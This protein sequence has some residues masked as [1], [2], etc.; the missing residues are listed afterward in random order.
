MPA[1]RNAV[2][3]RCVAVRR[4]DVCPSTHLA[5]TPLHEVLEQPSA[6]FEKISR[7]WRLWRR[8]DVAPCP[9]P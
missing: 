8:Q 7:A 9:Q 4:D 6:R 1:G 5:S 2:R 3:C